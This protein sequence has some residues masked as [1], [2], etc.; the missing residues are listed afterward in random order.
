MAHANPR[1]LIST[2]LLVTGALVFGEALHQSVVAGEASLSS[3]PILLALALGTVLI[4]LGYWVRVPLDELTRETSSSRSESAGDDA[5]GDA[6]ADSE[7]DP[8]LSPLGNTPSDAH[9]RGAADG[10]GADDA[11]ELRRETETRSENDTPSEN[12]TDS[13]RRTNTDRNIE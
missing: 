10:R 5:L 2:V 3:Q 8:R 9:D 13:A 12:D 7:Y 4:A 11:D 6:P 1:N